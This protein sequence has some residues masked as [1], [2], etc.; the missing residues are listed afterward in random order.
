MTAILVFL[1]SAEV[2]VLA[3]FVTFLV[4]GRFTNEIAPKYILQTA[5]RTEAGEREAQTIVAGYEVAEHLRIYQVRAGSDRRQ[6]ERRGR[7]TQSAA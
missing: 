3:M 7:G 2:L 5:P 1:V 6:A 4:V